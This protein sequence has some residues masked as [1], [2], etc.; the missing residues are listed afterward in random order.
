MKSIISYLTERPRQLFLIDAIGALLTALSLF[1]M[2][3]FSNYVGVPSGTLSILYAAAI[4]F[5]IYSA[6]CYVFIKQAWQTY[7]KAIG[8]L[9]LMYCIASVYVIISCFATITTLGLAYFL[10]EIGILVAVAIIEL[11]VAQKQ[12]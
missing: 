6:L 5:C 3:R 10:V 7:L 4:S 2:S 8:F 9:N 12:Y 11:K 1:V